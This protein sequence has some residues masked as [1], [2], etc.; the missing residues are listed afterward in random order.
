M[1]AMAS[2]LAIVSKALFEKMVPKDVKLGTVVDVDRYVS[3]NKTFDGLAKGG[4]IFM[5]T[6]RPPDEK[7]W[8][9]AILEKPKKKGDAWTSG[10]NETPLTDVTAAIKDLEFESGTG[11]KAK[12]GAL[13]MSLQTP[14]ALTA[15]DE[16]LLRGFVSKG[17]KKSGAK[18]ADK[19]TASDA[20]RAAVDDVLAGGKK[21][22]K[23]KKKANGAGKAAPAAT[24][25][26]RLEHARKPFEGKITDLS[27]SEKKQLEA[28]V[29]KGKLPKAFAEGGD[30]ELAEVTMADV[31]D[32][33]TGKT[34]YQLYLF[35]YGDGCVFEN[36]SL[37]IAADIC[38]HGF[39][40]RE[41]KSK[42]FTQDF[43]HAWVEGSKRLKL[44]TGHIDFDDD[45]LGEEEDDD[46]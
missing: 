23:K 10:S 4:A 18:K 31:V 25:S 41:E 24:G 46:D 7:L 29:G 32:A 16:K 45:E 5:V 1:A 27:A 15:D 35:G 34:Q 28:I 12:K 8:L 42:A 17:A 20:Y 11:I 37:E 39:D 14:R 19:V 22:K 9:V 21:K 36:G 40:A 6:V 2:V 3:N 30:E 43:A 38:Q 13:G 33:K 26:L 44:W